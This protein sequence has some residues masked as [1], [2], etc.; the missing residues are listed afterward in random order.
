MEIA[1]AIKL[2]DDQNVNN[3]IKDI[4]K[5]ISNGEYTIKIET[6]T[7]LQSRSKSP[8]ERI[9]LTILTNKYKI[10]LELRLEVKCIGLIYEGIKEGAW[11]RIINRYGEELYA[12]KIEI[13]DEA[14]ID[15][16]KIA[17]KEVSNFLK[18]IY[19]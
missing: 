16:L 13:C 3:I 9:C 4:L 15:I 1:D 12:K 10:L 17:D 14:F 6:K 7:K 18:Y 5:D 2:S 8:K 19:S 11:V